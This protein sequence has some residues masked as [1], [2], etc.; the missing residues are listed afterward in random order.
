[1]KAWSGFA[2]LPAGLFKKNSSPPTDLSH[3]CPQTITAAANT[4]LP[5]RQT[6]Q[7]FTRHSLVT[8]TF[9]NL[10]NDA[11]DKRLQLLEDTQSKPTIILLHCSNGV[12]KGFMVYLHSR[13]TGEYKWKLWHDNEQKFFYACYAK[14]S[15]KSS[16]KIAHKT[17]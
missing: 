7:V 13:Q 5:F 4:Q 6:R 15:I 9:N 14:L 10:E 8:V 3:P 2:A 11:G 12:A 16:S 17:N 1:M